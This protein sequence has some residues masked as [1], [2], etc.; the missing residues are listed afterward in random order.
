MLA[1]HTVRGLAIQRSQ[2]A[3]LALLPGK[4]PLEQGEQPHQQGAQ[5]GK[6]RSFP[7][8]DDLVPQLGTLVGKLCRRIGSA[9]SRREFASE[10]RIA[11]RTPLL[12]P[13]GAGDLPPRLLRKMQAP[14]ARLRA[15][16]RFAT[17]GM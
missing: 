9:R 5:D 3:C 8:L 11:H 16:Q 13:R 12:S 17:P 2:I 14:P 15:G 10:L 4:A 1:A 7:D 6:V